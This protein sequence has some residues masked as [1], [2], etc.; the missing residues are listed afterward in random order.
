VHDSVNELY[1]AYA[2]VPLNPDVDFCHHCVSPEQVAALHS[3]PLREIPADT[4]RRLLT[5]GLSTW[6]D[7][8]YFRHF[9]PRLLELTAAGALN[10]SSVGT[11]LP[12]RLSRCLE[13]GTAEERIALERFLNAWWTDTLSRYPA[14][15]DALAVY[16]MITAAGQPGAPLLAAL[17]EAAPGHVASFVADSAIGDPPP[18]IAG[19]LRS[20]VPAALLTAAGNTTDDLELLAHIG[21]ALEL[22]GHNY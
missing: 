1:R 5:K 13:A 2:L 9:L 7:E 16:E 11:Y 20:D 18:E 8:S 6:G 22:L 15:L 12:W 3:Y 14:P 19:W 17:P 4:I 21:W 10:D